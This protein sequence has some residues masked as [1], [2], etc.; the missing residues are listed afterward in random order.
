MA[1]CEPLPLAPVSEIPRGMRVL[2]ACSSELNH[3]ELRHFLEEHR[4]LCIVGEAFDWH[5]LCRLV[6]EYLPEAIIASSDLIRRAA[7]RLDTVLPALVL[8]SETPSGI[9]DSRITAVL[10]APCPTSQQVGHVVDAVKDVVIHAKWHDIL[11]LL[12]A[13]R[14]AAQPAGYLTE[15][16][17]ALHNTTVKVPIHQ[18]RCITAARNYIR[19]DTVSGTFQTRSPLSEISSRLDPQR[20]VRIHRSAIVNRANICAIVRKDGAPVA[21]TLQNGRRL[22]VGSTYRQAS[23]DLNGEVSVK[24]LF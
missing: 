21:V 17:V 22:P 20:F 6:D 4:D 12:H 15:I 3:A 19:L 9:A 14:D 1:A 10:P 24:K 13:S 23:L 2:L 18:V 8:V 16:D 7:Q 11:Q 5:T